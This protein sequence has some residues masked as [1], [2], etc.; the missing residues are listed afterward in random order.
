[1]D[2]RLLGKLRVADARQHVGDR[3]THTHGS[4]HQPGLLSTNSP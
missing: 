2:R 4:P 3:I 1:M